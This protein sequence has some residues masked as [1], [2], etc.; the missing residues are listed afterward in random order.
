MVRLRLATFQDRIFSCA[1]WAQQTHCL[2]GFG[3]RP[4]N[5]C[6]KQTWKITFTQ[7]FK[8]GIQFKGLSPEV[9][10]P[11]IDKGMLPCWNMLRVSETE[12]LYRDTSTK[13]GTRVYWHLASKKKVHLQQNQHN[14]WGNA[15]STSTHAWASCNMSYILKRSTQAWMSWPFWLCAHVRVDA[16]NV[17]YNVDSDIFKAFFP[18]AFLSFSFPCLPRAQGI[19]LVMHQQKRSP[20]LSCW[21]EVIHSGL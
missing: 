6:M 11:P 18:I 17:W 16:F 10:S 7:C 2:A 3:C 13:D 1:L 14:V 12:M 4:L 15:G 8:C 21:C 19:L 5:H 9:T 20:W